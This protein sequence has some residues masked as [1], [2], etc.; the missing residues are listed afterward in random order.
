M[1]T[2]LWTSAASWADWFYHG[3]SSL[4]TWTSSSFEARWIFPLKN[5]FFSFF[6]KNLTVRNPASSDL[7][8]HRDTGFAQFRHYTSRCV[9]CHCNKTLNVSV[10]KPTLTDCPFSSGWRLEDPF[11]FLAQFPSFLW[12]YTR[13]LPEELVFH[14]FAV[15]YLLQ[16]DPW[17][18]R[19]FTVVDKIEPPKKSKH[20]LDQFLW[21]FLTLSSKRF[22][23]SSWRFS[24]S[25]NGIFIR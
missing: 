22:E 8:R 4:F 12:V 19:V 11:P 15:G 18:S 2:A 14:G 20:S 21:R 1:L 7:F 3:S 10:I 9:D 6:I 25:W 16:L 5:C 13:C 23:S 17:F 24:V